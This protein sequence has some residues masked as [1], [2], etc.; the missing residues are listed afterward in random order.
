[1]NV[2]RN[3]LLSLLVIVALSIAACGSPAASPIV[4]AAEPEP[5]L[6]CLTVEGAENYIVTIHDDYGI[7]TTLSG[8]VPVGSITENSLAP[9]E[10][11]V[12]MTLGDNANVTIPSESLSELSVIVNSCETTHWIHIVVA[13]DTWITMTNALTPKQ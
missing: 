3:T 10:Y 13:D 8:N 7:K 2:K 4:I 11:Y 6:E 1:M 9:G 12:G 5:E